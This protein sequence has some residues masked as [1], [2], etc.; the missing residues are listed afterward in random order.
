MRVAEGIAQAIAAGEPVVALESTVIAHGL[1]APDNLRTAEACEEAVRSQGAWP[2]TMA[3]VAG[4]VTVGL[5]ATQ[6]RELSTRQGVRKVN[7]A[8]FASVVSRGEWGATTVAASLHLAATT[9]IQVFA[10]GGIGGVHRGAEASF[11]LSADLMALARYPVVTVCAGAKAILDLPRTREVLETLGIPVLGFQ[12]DELPA[13]YSA[14]SG[15]PVDQRVETVDE[16]VTVARRHWALG[17]TSGVL[18]VVPPPPE[19][20]IAPAQLNQWIE[21]ALEAA[22]GQGIRGKAVTPYLLAWLAEH[23]AQRTLRVNC[24]LL[25][26]NAAIGGAIAA[27]GVAGIPRTPSFHPNPVI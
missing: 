13:F 16:V 12:T 8:N 27:A 26:Q 19:D 2:A 1:P 4:E 15:L 7:P 6:L 10:T 9:G 11:D 21:A 25:A 20:A 22:V 23:S 5:D 18:V 17:W 24:S 3:I 14:T